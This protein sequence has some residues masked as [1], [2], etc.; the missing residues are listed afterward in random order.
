M[1]L[2]YF[3]LDT[4]FRSLPSGFEIYFSSGEVH[5][6]FSPYCLAGRNGSGKSNLLEVLAS[7]FFHL[8]CMTLVWRPEALADFDSSMGNPAAYFL[9]Y[10]L[11]K[12]DYDLRDFDP[13]DYGYLVFVQIEKKLGKAPEIRIREGEAEEFGAPLERKEIRNYLPDFVIGYSSGENEILSLPFQ[14]MRLIHFDEYFSAVMEETGYSKPEGRLIYFDLPFSQAV[15]LTNYLMQ[16]RKVIKPILRKLGIAGILSFRIIVNLVKK[17]KEG[18]LDE[19]GLKYEIYGGPREELDLSTYVWQ[20]SIEDASLLRILNRLERCATTHYHNLEENTLTF[21]FFLDPDPL[22]ENGNEIFDAER[23]RVRLG[24]T[25][26]AFQQHFDYDPLDLF[27]AFQI[28]LT[29]NLYDVSVETKYDYYLSDS[30]YSN[31]TLPILPSDKRFMRFKDF[32]LVKEK[33][34]SK[35]LSKSL[36]DGEHQ[37]LHAMGIC[38]L[39]G[40]TNSLI[41]LDEP[42]T[43]LNPDWRASFISTLKDCLHPYKDQETSILP[44][45]LISSHSPFIISDCQ[46]E[47]VL[48]F[49]KGNTTNLVEVNR[50]DFETFGSS[51]NKITMKIFGRLETIGGYAQEFRDELERKLESGEL[52]PDE[53]IEEA[54]AKLGD[55]VEKVFL[56]NKAL[57]KKE[58]Q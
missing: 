20:S 52:T 31:E 3:R 48:I 34:E 22:D 17:E 15:F 55:S 50:P 37:Y 9:T 11:I 1:R 16:P 23:N 41:L 26:T 45:F 38:L 33:L 29:L 7:I 43:H 10:S 13:S 40:S 6:P 25:K 39:F 30:L 42:E 46:K 27:Q 53:V 18:P 35:L 32:W 28:L 47:N 58:K 49:K 51:V 57:D 5:G 12:S 54:N 24:F 4:P 36:S 19:K 44:E 8:E 56:I 14:K 2:Q 21:D